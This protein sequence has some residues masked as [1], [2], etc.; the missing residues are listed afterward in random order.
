MQDQ[1]PSILVVDDLKSSRI[2]ICKILHALGLIHV[3]TANCG[4]AALESLRSQRPET[5]FLDWVMPEMTGIEVLQEIRKE[6]ELKNIPVA[7][8][9]SCSSKAKVVKALQSGANDYIVN[10]FSIETVQQKLSK[11]A[12]VFGG[13]LSPN[14]K[15]VSD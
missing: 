11:F 2:I 9:T 14:S 13:S 1:E 6:S 8:V 10:P 4:K 15:T 7:M 3:R 12:P 5:V